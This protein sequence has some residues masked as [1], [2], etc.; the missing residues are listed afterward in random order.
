MRAVRPKCSCSKLDVSCSRPLAG[1]PLVR[2]AQD[3]ASV[4]YTMNTGSCAG[5][6]V[7][8]CNARCEFVQP[9]GEVESLVRQTFGGC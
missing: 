8:K 7:P 1:D 9:G 4:C 5:D 2:L 6:A 3:G